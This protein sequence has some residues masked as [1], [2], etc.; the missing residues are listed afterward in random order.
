MALPPSEAGGAKE[1][2]SSALPADMAVMDG[3]S[4]TVAGVTLTAA[5][6]GL[7]PMALRA[8]TEQL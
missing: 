2:D 8:V 5:D 3:A 7:G 1:M 4:G 6:A